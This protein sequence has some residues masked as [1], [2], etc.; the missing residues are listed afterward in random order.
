MRKILLALTMLLAS[1]QFAQANDYSD[2][3]QQLICNDWANFSQVVAQRFRDGTGDTPDKA[4]ESRVKE[5]LEAES[6]RNNAIFGNDQTLQAIEWVSFIY[7]HPQ[8]APGQIFDEVTAKCMAPPSLK[9][10]H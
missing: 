5:L 3:T 8:L 10:S 9:T 6:T 4:D 7:A 1:C 2:T